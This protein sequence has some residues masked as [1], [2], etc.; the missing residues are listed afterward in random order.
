M[1]RPSRLETE[2][3][4]GVDQTAQGCRQHGGRGRQVHGREVQGRREGRR[5]SGQEHLGQHQGRH[6]LVWLHG[7]EFLYGAL[8]QLTATIFAILTLLTLTF[9]GCATMSDEERCK[10]EGGV[11]HDKICERQAK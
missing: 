10:K 11:W 6:I 2:I 9:A 1:R 3:G 8:Q 7:E 4:K 5:A